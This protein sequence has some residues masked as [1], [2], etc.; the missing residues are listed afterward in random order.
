MLAVTTVRKTNATNILRT[1]DWPVIL[2]MTTDRPSMPA[3]VTAV[4]TRKTGHP[5]RR[6]NQSVQLTALR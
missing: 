4:Q 1:A 6:T 2:V 3:T 5:D